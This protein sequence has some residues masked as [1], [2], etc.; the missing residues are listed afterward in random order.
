MGKDLLRAAAIVVKSLTVLDNFA[1]EEGNS[2]VAREVGLLNGAL[3]LLGNANHRNN[4]ARRFIIKR[5]INQKCAHLCSDKAPM[6]RFLFSDDVSQSARQ[7]EEADRLKGKFSNR[8]PSTGGR[9]G[10]FRSATGRPFQSQALPRGF[11]ARFHPY[12]QRR[13]SSTGDARSPYPRQSLR[14]K[15]PRAGDTATPGVKSGKFS[16]CCWPT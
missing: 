12:G 13:S 9:L 5:E 6:T 10:A 2:V 11:S 7:I 3:A 4:L 1:Q 14:Q 8:R 15:T 16:F